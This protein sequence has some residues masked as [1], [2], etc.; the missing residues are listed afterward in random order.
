MT[1]NSVGSGEWDVIV[2]SSV[3]FLRI[4]KLLVNSQLID[5]GS[6]RK[7]FDKSLGRNQKHW[8][9]KWAILNCVITA[10]L[11]VELTT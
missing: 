10:A 2:T 8:Q 7:L 9:F 6:G 3:H 4:V 11:H 5:D 1:G